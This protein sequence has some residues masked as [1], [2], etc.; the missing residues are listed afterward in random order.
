M[1][2]YTPFLCRVTPYGTPFFVPEASSTNPW[3]IDNLSAQDVCRY[4]WLLEWVSI[5]YKMTFSGSFE[6]QSNLSLGGMYTSVPRMRI[7]APPQFSG[8]IFQPSSGIITEGKIDF[9]KIYLQEGGQYA[10]DFT[11]NAYSRDEGIG[12][13]DFLL[14]F[15][16]SVGDIGQRD[17]YKSQ[18]VDF[19]GKSVTVY[20]N[21]NSQIWPE[22]EI[23]LNS[24][25]LSASFFSND[26][27]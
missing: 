14:S 9:S 17:S 26:E 23:E 25:S 10:I 4:Y 7:I 22:D 11:F 21:Y 12:G 6:V 1:S 19:S 24:F 27:Q 18:T 3:I 16:R 2:T 8:S 5:A 13:S 15:Y 20:L